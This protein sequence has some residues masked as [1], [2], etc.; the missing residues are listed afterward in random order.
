M[1][2]DMMEN[3]VGGGDDGMAFEGVEEGE[4]VSHEVVSGE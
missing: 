2:Q 3:S 4:T 1:F